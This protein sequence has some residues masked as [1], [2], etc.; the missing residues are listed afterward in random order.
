MNEEIP[1]QQL[2]EALSLGLGLYFP[3][4]R[5]NDLDRGLKAASKDLGFINSIELA[6]LVLSHSLTTAHI[7]VL[8]RHLTIPETYFFR[9]RSTMLALRDQVLS[10]LIDERRDSE[11]RLRIWSA[12]CCSGEEPYTLAI[13]LREL[14]PDFESWR[15]SIL[16]TDINPVVLEKAAIG[17]YSD[18]SFREVPEGFKARYFSQQGNQFRLRSE[19]M[20]MV[21][22]SFLNLASDTFPSL[23]TNTE[24]MDLILC[25]NVL[26]YFSKEE[27]IRVVDKFHK[28]LTPGG[29]LVVSAG[30]SS[31]VSPE[32]FDC[33]RFSDAFFFKKR[34]L[35]DSKHLSRLALK[36]EKSSFKDS[37]S[38]GEELV[39]LR[40]EIPVSNLTDL[41]PAESEED[42]LNIARDFYKLGFYE[43]AVAALK[44]VRSMWS[45]QSKPVLQLQK[46][47]IALLAR[48][49]ANQGKLSEALDW[50]EQGIDLDPL[51][52]QLYYL[53]ANILQSQLQPRGALES[54][55][56]SLYLDPDFVLSH[57]ALGNYYLREGQ[58]VKA[59]RNYKNALSLALKMDKESLLPEGEGLTAG[60]LAGIV[61]TTLVAL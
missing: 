30:E 12:G 14:L 43:E 15:V 13:L 31:F 53:H 46:Q 8:A 5:W 44:T 49:R 33:V 50:C 39:N 60:R 11:H 20:K 36:L 16:G 48:S 22:F 7:K 3:E 34:Q 9:D 2:S 25:R 29:W 10:D 55:R 17:C 41:D 51:N 1:F 45:D 26:M 52:A 56:K 18:W 58:K 21:S 27:A 35:T 37:C 23:T 42:L 24:A 59:V 38:L 61:E 54:L 32:L 40:S 4:N 47:V 6:R 57:Y 28:C 19:L